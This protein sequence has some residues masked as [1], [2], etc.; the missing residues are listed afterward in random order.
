MTLDELKKGW[1]VLSERLSR[2][3]VINQRII[4]EMI[5][6]K[7]NSAYDAIYQSNKWGL[8]T[9][10][11]I[12]TF[13][14]PFCKMQGMPIYQETFIT[15][16]I[17]IFLGF[18][19]AVYMFHILSRFNLHTMKMDE[20]MRLVL[21]YKRMYIKKQ[22]YGKFIILLIVLICTILQQAF[23]LPVIIATILCIFISLFL[24]HKQDKHQRQYL[25][26]IE[27]GLHELKELELL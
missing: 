19:Y 27:N 7:T 5:L 3:E 4:K 25:Q 10:F 16:E 14:L 15:L 11:L 21:K 12:G 20:V 13:I 24:M 22:R 8:I 26:E 9:T 6:C 2:N 23:I 1:D 18:I 17:F